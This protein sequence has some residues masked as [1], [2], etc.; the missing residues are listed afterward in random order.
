ML[1][2]LLKAFGET[3]IDHFGHLGIQ[4]SYHVGQ[5]LRIGDG[6]FERAFNQLG[7][8]G[9]GVFRCVQLRNFANRVGGL[10]DNFLNDFVLALGHGLKALN[11]S[12]VDDAKA[13]MFLH[14]ASIRLLTLNSGT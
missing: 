11:G 9:G 12:L 8:L 10:L 7:L 5:F 13:S 2:D 4:G 3:G 1:A 6:F 14:W